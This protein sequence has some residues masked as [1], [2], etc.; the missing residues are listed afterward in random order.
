LDDLGSSFRLRQYRDVARLRPIFILTALA[1][2][3]SS[4]MF[5]LDV[6]FVLE[7]PMAAAMAATSS[8]AA[9]VSTMSMA[10]S[11]S[12]VVFAHVVLVHSISS[13]SRG[14]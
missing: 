3:L 5:K 1:I 13:S 4:G 7:L 10:M 11:L 9:A 6:V 2:V 12:L 14:R 8:T